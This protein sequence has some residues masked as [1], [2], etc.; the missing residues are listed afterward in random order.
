MKGCYILLNAFLAS[1][2][3]DQG[4]LFSFEFLYIVDCINGL[5]LLDLLNLL[6][7]LNQSCI[8]SRKTI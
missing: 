6:N 7:V 3:D 4:I 1:K 2:R 8:P 5:D